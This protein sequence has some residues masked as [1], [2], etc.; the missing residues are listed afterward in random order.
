[1]DLLQAGNKVTVRVKNILYPVRGLYAV[2]V[3]IPEYNEYTGVVVID[4]TISNEEIG[5]T[6]DS[7]MPLRRIRRDLIVKVNE[8]VVD[9]SDKS[10]NDNVTKTVTGSKG[11]T[12]IITKENGRA[13]C[14]CPGYNFRRTCRHVQELA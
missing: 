3:I 11:E 10:K 6:G 14:S 5:L 13:S 1:M 8:S 7:R 9:Y 4:K 12:Y 2:N